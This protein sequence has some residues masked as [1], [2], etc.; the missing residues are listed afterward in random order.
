MDKITTIDGY[1]E[2][3]EV[4]DIEDKIIEEPIVL[5][6]I[7]TTEKYDYVVRLL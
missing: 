5:E 3:I 7:R 6:P 2:I 1:E 4:I